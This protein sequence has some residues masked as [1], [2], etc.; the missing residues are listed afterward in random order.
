MFLLQHYLMSLNYLRE[1]EIRNS[2][3]SLAAAYDCH[4]ASPIRRFLIQCAI[5]TG[6]IYEKSF[7]VN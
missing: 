7:C 5:G 2:V 4:Q 1:G 3:E 6:F